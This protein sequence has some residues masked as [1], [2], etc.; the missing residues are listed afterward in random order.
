[1]S[2]RPLA[3]L[4]TVLLALAACGGPPTPV[5]PTPDP[6]SPLPAASPPASTAPGAW[7]FPTDDGVG[8]EPGRYASAPPFDVAFTFEV[9]DAGWESMHLHGEFF[10][11]GRFDTDERPAQP[12][13]W[14]GWAHPDHVRG[15]TDEPVAG[16]TPEEAAALLASRDDVTAS[17][18]VPFA[19]AELA[20][21]RLDLHASRPN[22]L[23]FGGA[24]GN[25]GLEPSHD[26][27]LGIVPLDER[28]VFV[29]VLAAPAELDAA[30]AEAAPILEGVEL[31]AGRAA[32]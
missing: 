29:L 14:I 11:I 7:P 23:L 10:D 1:M 27:R 24:D 31:A 20:G 6:A 12:V 2:H 4:A 19:F 18:P 32:G 13:R 22:T 8:L 21:V 9:D 5:S 17:E 15:G 26:L 3:A 16:M 28:L 30:W 25:F